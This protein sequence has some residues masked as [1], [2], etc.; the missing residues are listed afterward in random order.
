MQINRIISVVLSVTI[1]SIAPSVAAAGSATINMTF[2]YASGQPVA[3]QQVSCNSRPPQNG[4]YPVPP[5]FTYLT[6]DANGK[7]SWTVNAQD[8][9][10]YQCNNRT[11]VTPD[12]CYTWSSATTP[13]LSL[14]GGENLNYTFTAGST[15]A[16]GCAV[17]PTPP[18]PTTPSNQT[19]PTATTATPTSSNPVAAT[20]KQADESSKDDAEKPAVDP[21][22][23]AAKET[24]RPTDASDSKNA[25]IPI[26]VGVASLMALAMIALAAR[27]LLKRRS[28]QAVAD[29][30]TLSER[31]KSDSEL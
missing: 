28:R 29:A 15:P 16:A 4:P 25:S 8:G 26:S 23:K 13:G 20:D 12:N 7:V 9:Y 27:Q 30:P 10:T 22:P 24:S 6:A 21:K 31:N 19:A 11:W 5:Q 1:L 17:A 3:G 2:L 18:P 14:A